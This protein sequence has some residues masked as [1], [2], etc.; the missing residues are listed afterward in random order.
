M[1]KFD[2]ALGLMDRGMSGYNRGLPHGLERL[3]SI[4]PNVQQGT[5]YTIGGET[6]SGKTAF[7]DNSFLFAPY[8]YI[9]N[10]D[11]IKLKILYFSL[12]IEYTY[13]LVK[14]IG[15]KLFLDYGIS[16]GLNQ[17]LS[18]GNF[19]LSKEIRAKIDTYREYFEELEDILE[20]YDGHYTPEQIDK[21]I[22]QYSDENGQWIVPKGKEN[23]TFYK[24]NDPHLYTIIII[25]H[26]GLIDGMNMK[27]AIDKT[28]RS[29]IFYRNMCNFTPVIVSQFN[30][31]ISSADRFKIERV[32][33]QLSDF[34]DSSSTQKDAN[35]VM[36][37]FAPHR[38]SLGN[39]HG[40]DIT[41]LDKEFRGLHILKNR[42][43][44]DNAFLGL[45][46]NGAVGHFD[47]YPRPQEMKY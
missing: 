35:V 24:P 8:D 23:K 18:R 42:D 26:V 41:R 36:A 1:S 29:L 43:G 34:A 15:R 22:K 11:I 31:T 21:I 19:T 20:I 10:K 7:T 12:E 30:R 27:A 32:E 9:K 37:L 47:E 4:V 38:Y 40:Y 45:K 46:F 25:D 14:G 44:A 13:K 5:Y 28:S 16:L 2:N 33:P 17:L 3:K 6:G 39:Y